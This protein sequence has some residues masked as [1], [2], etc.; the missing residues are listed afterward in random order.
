MFY[1]LLYMLIG[2][3]VGTF[4][5][6]IGLGG[7]VIMVPALLWAYKAQGISDNLAIHMAAG[8]SLSVIVFTS[9]FSLYNHLKRGAKIQPIYRQLAAGIII[10]TMLGAIFGHFLPARMI[11]ILFGVFILFVSIRMVLAIKPKPGRKLPGKLGMFLVAGGIGGKSGVLG[12]GGGAVTTIFLN[13]CNVPLRNIIAISAACSST[14][15]VVGAVSFMLIGYNMPNL[16][17]W[18]TGYVYWPGFLGI[19]LTGPIF[20]KLGTMLSYKLPVEILKRILGVILVMAAI[21]MIAI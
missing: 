8:T 18:S 10:G 19:L 14:V 17:A 12:V 1:F 20:A 21:K 13:Y 6:L 5:G 7:G 3:A 4:S 16:P 2:S 9:L 15:A 11:E